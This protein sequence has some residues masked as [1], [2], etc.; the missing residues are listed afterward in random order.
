MSQDPAPPPASRQDALGRLRTERWHAQNNGETGRVAELDED[1][2]RLSARNSATSPQ[3]EST[4]AAPAAHQPAVP[5][6]VRRTT[7]KRNK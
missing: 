7:T 2:A 1:I 6:P 5:G 3:R 4:A